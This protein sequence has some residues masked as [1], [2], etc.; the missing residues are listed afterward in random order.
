MPSSSWARRS[1]SRHRR[2][3][4]RPGCGTVAATTLRF[5]PTQRQAWL[6]DLDASVRADGALCA[7]HAAAFVL[8]RGWE[9]PD[10]RTVVPTWSRRSDGLG[11]VRRLLVLLV[12]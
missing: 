12:H 11:S 10:G 7:R 2:L 5:Q 8:P 9:F 6:I 1:G 4:A 3:C